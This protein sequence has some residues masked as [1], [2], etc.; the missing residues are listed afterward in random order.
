M[1]TSSNTNHNVKEVLP[2]LHVANMG[3]SVRF[4]LDGIGFTMKHNGVVEG[5]LRW[6]WLSLGG[7]SLMLQEFPKR[8]T[9]TVQ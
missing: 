4:Y 7:A 9:I 3:L 2:F 6:C 8:G 5:R 1:N